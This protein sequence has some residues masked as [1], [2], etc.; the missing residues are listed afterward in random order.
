MCHTLCRLTHQDKLRAEDHAVLREDGVLGWY[1]YKSKSGAWDVA[2][3]GWPKKIFVFAANVFAILFSNAVTESELSFQHAYVGGKGGKRGN[4]GSHNRRNLGILRS[5]PNAED[6]ARQGLQPQFGDDM[7]R[8]G[9][10]H[11]NVQRR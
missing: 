4:M 9:A 6:H 5:A 2:S 1:N 7:L 10:T 3:E 8:R 11:S